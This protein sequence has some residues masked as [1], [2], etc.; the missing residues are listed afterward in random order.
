MWVRGSQ[1]HAH[2]QLLAVCV[3]DCLCVCIYV[4]VCVCVCRC[5]LLNMQNG[6]GLCSTHSLHPWG[7]VQRQC[8]FL[9]VYIRTQC[10]GTAPV[11][12][13]LDSGMFP[14][15][16]A[17]HLYLVWTM[18]Q[19]SS[20]AQPIFA[21]ERFN[22]VKDMYILQFNNK[23]YCLRWHWCAWTVNLTVNLYIPMHQSLR[24]IILV[25]MRYDYIK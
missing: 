9:Y 22:I 18:S 14:A 8:A 10:V 7:L 12:W 6:M 5:A 21:S 24:L 17:T 1:V 2:Q 19:L 16:I 15:D 11:D 3:R 25:N 23:S 13:L 20:K 4:C